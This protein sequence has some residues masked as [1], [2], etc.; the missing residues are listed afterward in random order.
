MLLVRPLSREE[1]DAEGDQP[2]RP[3]LRRGQAE[4]ERVIA[5]NQLDQQA[6]DA[7]QPQEGVPNSAT[8]V[9]RSRSRRSSPAITFSKQRDH[10]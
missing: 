1:D 9:R 5:A 7:E 6:L 3:H 10:E 4:D 8:G 2:E